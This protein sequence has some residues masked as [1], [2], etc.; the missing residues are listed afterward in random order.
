[1]TYGSTG[2]L[3]H[4]EEPDEHGHRDADEYIDTRLPGLGGLLG[5]GR[6]VMLVI[7]GFLAFNAYSASHRGNIARN[8]ESSPPPSGTPVSQSS[9]TDREAH[10]GLQ[11]G[12]QIRTQHFGVLND[13]S[14]QQRVSEIGQKL[15]AQS[16]AN[17]TPYEFRFDVLADDRGLNTYALPGGQVYVTQGLL[18]S[19]RTEGEV[20]GMLAHAIG[21]VVARHNM[22]QIAR[23]VLPDGSVGR[24]VFANYDPRNP[25]VATQSQY[26]QLVNHV[27]V[28]SYDQDQELAS[29]RLALEFMVAA[30]YD[31]RSLISA[32]QVLQSV[33][34][35]QPSTEFFRSHPNHLGRIQ[36]LQL[37]IERQYPRLPSTLLR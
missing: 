34:Q 23:T 9:Q 14:I 29:D 12:Q 20:A 35:T 22:D 7:M 27:A 17:Q 21:H 28:I 6:V 26:A 4:H 11:A 37:E 2:R 30:G 32:L 1:M 25:T 18:R 36:E 3:D 8:V 5:R 15:I 13:Q 31:P 19:M 16:R 10:L 33:H 24:V